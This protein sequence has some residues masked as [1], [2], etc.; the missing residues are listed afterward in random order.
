M[1]ITTKYN[2]WDK[3]YVM[4]NDIWKGKIELR[5]VKINAIDIFIRKKTEIEYLIDVRNKGEYLKRYKE[6]EIY[7]SKEEYIKTL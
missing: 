3:V 7:F 2:V 4:V 6:N 1:I 5:K